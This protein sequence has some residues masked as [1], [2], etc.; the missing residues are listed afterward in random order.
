LADYL[1]IHYYFQANTTINDGPAKALRLRATRSLWDPTYIDESWVG[2]DSQNHQPNP[3]A[4]W[5]IP[6]MKQIIAQYYPGTKLMLSEWASSADTDITGGLVTADML[7][8]FG[9]Y[10][11]D[12]A[13]YWSNP[14]ERGPV[15]L[16]FWLYRGYG[17]NQRQRKRQL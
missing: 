6:R 3:N 10:G 11:L 14:D 15:G 12:A 1:D 8:I 7:G 9:R 4:I 13:T 2:S 17:R 5:L 16:A